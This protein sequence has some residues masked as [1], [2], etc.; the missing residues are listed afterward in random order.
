[1]IDAY[2]T[3]KVETDGS[4]TIR[5]P[6]SA[7]NLEG[8]IPNETTRAWV[9]E[10]YVQLSSGLG[11]RTLKRFAG[12]PLQLSLERDDVR[13]ALIV[14]NKNTY[15]WAT[16]AVGDGGDIK[17]RND[18]W[19]Q[20]SEI[21]TY[22]GVPVQSVLAN[23]A[24][25]EDPTAAIFEAKKDRGL[26]RTAL[27]PAA[28]GRIQFAGAG[29]ETVRGIFEDKNLES[30]KQRIDYVR[31]NLASTSR[32]KPSAVRIG[33]DGQEKP[34]FQDRKSLY[35]IDAVSAGEQAASARQVVSITERLIML[36][37]ANLASSGVEG[38]AIKLIGGLKQIG[39]S[40]LSMAETYDMTESSRAKLKNSSEELR[41]AME[42]GIDGKI[43]GQ[44]LF[45]LL[46]EQLAFA[47]AAAFQ[48]GEGGRA[49]SDRDVEAQRAVLGLRSLLASEQG[50]RKNLMYL[51]QEFSRIAEINTAYA[52]AG[53]SLDFKAAYIVDHAGSQPRSIKELLAKG[54]ITQVDKAFDLDAYLNETPG[55]VSGG[56]PALQAVTLSNGQTINV[57]LAK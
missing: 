5:D 50:S 9:V 32:V 34:V 47:M 40:L 7:L 20:A 56:G 29:K 14:P 39:E 54:N 55:I 12:I 15:A 1:M 25:F 45:N 6:L 26:I 33:G 36:Q 51:K 43:E 57:E 27:T 35:S 2:T 53:D 16:E 38:S 48:K 42:L 23:F 3:S 11:L 52:E 21:S 31:Q 13:G 49:I 8:L 24:T 28:S 22:S 18:I 10:Q 44:A 37:D 17:I 41:K 30:T 46:A 4:R 19:K